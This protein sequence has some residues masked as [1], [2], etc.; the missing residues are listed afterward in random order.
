MSIMS[1]IIRILLYTTNSSPHSNFKTVLSPVD[2]LVT[3]FEKV[4]RLQKF[5]P[6]INRL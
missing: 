5:L 4:I 2:D 3:H 6:P 1:V